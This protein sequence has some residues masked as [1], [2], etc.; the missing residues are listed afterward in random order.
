MRLK[1]RAPDVAPAESN[2]IEKVLLEF[3]AS[4]SGTS[5]NVCS[6]HS[7]G[8]DFDGTSVDPKM[9]SVRFDCREAVNE[10]LYAPF[11]QKEPVYVCCLTSIPQYP[12]FLKPILPVPLTDATRIDAG[13]ASDKGE[14]RN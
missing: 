8:T 7:S 3:D 10:P 6:V 2:V 1:S 9:S 12:S 13:K 4:F 14:S 5:S 11:T